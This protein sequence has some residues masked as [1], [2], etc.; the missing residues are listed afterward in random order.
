MRVFTKLLIG[1]AILLPTVHAFG[2]EKVTFRIST[3]PWSAGGCEN[4][5]GNPSCGYWSADTPSNIVYVG[6]IPGSEC[7][8]FADPIPRGGRATSVDLRFAYG[9]ISQPI[10]T[11]VW[12]DALSRGNDYLLGSFTPDGTSP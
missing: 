4:T 3:T 5:T 2:E 1:L 11:Q 6:L 7:T 9:P 12:I 8:E 10:L